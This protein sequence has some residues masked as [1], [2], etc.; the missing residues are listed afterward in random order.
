MDDRA[1]YWKAYYQS[2]KEKHK[3]SARDWYIKNRERAKA[4]RR[5]YYQRLREELDKKFS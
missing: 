3:K 5:K 4:R 2:H 1:E